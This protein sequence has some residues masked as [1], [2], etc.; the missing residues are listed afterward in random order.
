M[1]SVQDL[2]RLPPHRDSSEYVGYIYWGR[3]GAR[4]IVQFGRTPVRDSVYFSHAI[5]DAGTGDPSQAAVDATLPL[6]RAVEARLE[7]VP[8]WR[9]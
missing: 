2:S 5:S 6:M 7:S 1:D 4:A 9:A 3:D 8:G